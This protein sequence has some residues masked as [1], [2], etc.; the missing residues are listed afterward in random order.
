VIRVLEILAT[1]Q[2]AGAEN[3]AVSLATGL[4]PQRF[5]TAV[6]SLYDAF[7]QGLE[8][9]LADAGVPVWHLGKRHGFDPRMYARLKRVM[10]EFNPD[11]IHTHSYVM[12]YTLPVARGKMVHTVHN[13]A[14]KEVDGLGRMV[15]RVAFR[16]GVVP[17]A[18]ASEIA[19]SF[20]DVYGFAP[21]A[22]IPNGVNADAMYRPE[23]RMS[24]RAAHGFA[25]DE[26]LVVSVARLDAQKNPLLL[27]D[28]FARVARGQL[29]LAGQGS[30]RSH[31][32]GR[33]RVHLLGL[34]T[35]VPELLSAC[36]IFAL[37]SNW[38]GHP[39]AILEAMAAGLPVVATAVGGV[40]EIVEHGR[41][42]LLVSPGDTGAF[43]A[44]INA[45]A[46]D[47]GL[48]R[49]IGQAAREKAMCFSVSNMVESYAALF[50]RLTCASSC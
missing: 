9:V 23:A 12:R 16:R 47:P 37:A 24:W 8:L 50:S 45:L 44:A 15:H 11:I 39:V 34:R 18:I 35:D 21:A 48:R 41:T 10:R 1:L 13:M 3:V 22:V 2:R 7:P 4:D 6:V 33:E 19:G 32:E 27:A 46:G 43:A 5:R 30:L 25:A 31:L 36:D 40:P 38:E 28:A 14:D 29:L 49:E 42:G 20:H 26:L 17:V